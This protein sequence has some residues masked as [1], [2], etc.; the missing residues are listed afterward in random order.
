MAGQVQPDSSPHSP[1]HAL[2]SLCED[3]RGHAVFMLQDQALLQRHRHGCAVLGTLAAGESNP[4]KAA[5]DL[6]TGNGLF[7][8]EKSQ[9]KGS[10][11]KGRGRPTGLA[12]APAVTPSPVL[13]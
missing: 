10:T 3:L 2:Q 7:L 6:P 8:G 9:Q 1:A 11:L 12:G 4:I 13:A 5:A